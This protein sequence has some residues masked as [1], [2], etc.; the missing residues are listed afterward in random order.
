MK[1]LA[2]EYPVW[3]KSRAKQL[4]LEKGGIARDTKN[5]IVKES[6]NTLILCCFFICEIKKKTSY[7]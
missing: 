6:Y 3:R 7:Q 2:Y 1:Y 5:E 4:Q